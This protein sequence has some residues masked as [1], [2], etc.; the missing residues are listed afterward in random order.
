MPDIVDAELHWWNAADLAAAIRT[1]HVSSAEIVACFLDRIEELDR[2]FNAFLHLM[3]RSEVMAE[4]HAADAA[5]ARGDE[6]GPLHGL[7]TG[8]KDLMD[9]A[10]MPTTSGA[11]VLSAVATADCLLAERIRGG[12]A[13]I[14]GKTNT[15]LHGLGTLTFNDLGGPT[16]NPWDRTRHAGGSSGGA[17][18]AIAAG[19]LP[20]A[21]GSDSG[22]SLRY[23]ASFC[24]IVGLRPSPGRVPTGRISNGWAP[25]AVLGPMARNARDTGLLLSAIAGDDW[26]APIALGGDP[27][28][29]AAI[30]AGDLA[31]LRIAWSNSVGG[32]PVDPEVQQVLATARERLFELGCIVEDVDLDLAD[33]DRAW[34]IIE[35]QDFAAACGDDVARFGE[36]LRDDLI[37]NVR[38][39]QA[40]TVTEIA[41]AE[42]ARTEMYRRTAKL[43]QQYDLIAT[44]AAPVAAPP[45]E[46][47]WVREIAGEVMSRYYGWQ[48]IACR[49]TMT[50]HPALSMPAG[51]TKDG[52]PV[53]LQLVGRYRDEFS[54]LQSAAAFDDATGFSRLRPRDIP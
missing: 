6:L 25:H 12:G 33:A 10:G 1:R 48:R 49:I 17:A 52:L 30:E 40:L 24:N 16:R 45:A 19:M 43:L 20:F 15:P 11:A 29:Y 26:R 37:E 22:G 28:V 5:V 44:P 8:V 51:F 14:I 9:V 32:L 23:P 31:G 35:F 47:E 21:D 7:P 2:H 39:G 3:P 18:A 53:G 36:A 4:A 34:E 54:L 38:I 27:A 13:I 42:T 41:W 46:C 50:A